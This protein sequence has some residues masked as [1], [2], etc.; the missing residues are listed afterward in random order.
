MRL[1][2]EKPHILVFTIN[3]IASMNTSVYLTLKINVFFS[4]LPQNNIFHDL[5]YHSICR[6]MHQGA[7]KNFSGQP[8]SL[9]SNCL[10]CNLKK[11]KR[12]TLSLEES[13]FTSLYDSYFR[14]NEYQGIFQWHCAI[15]RHKLQSNPIYF[16]LYA[17]L[18]FELLRLRLCM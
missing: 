12:H 9:L 17:L 2:D 5:L 18:Q 8:L 7:L 16:I 4:H 1:L 3:S 14:C 10:K 15:L 11:F 13:S 6:C